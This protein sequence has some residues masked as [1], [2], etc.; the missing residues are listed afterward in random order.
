MSYDVFGALRHEP[1]LRSR[2]AF[3]ECENSQFKEKQSVYISEIR[4]LKISA[5]VCEA[6]S[7]I[8]FIFL[9]FN[10]QSKRTFTLDVLA[11]LALEDV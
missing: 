11:E 8:A 7:H 10:M 4:R 1:V 3:G 9:K 5:A 2:S 6:S